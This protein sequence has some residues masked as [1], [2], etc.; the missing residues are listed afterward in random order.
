M[1]SIA[2]VKLIARKAI[3]DAANIVGIIE[4]LESS[5]TGKVNPTINAANAG[6]AALQIQLS[7]IWRLHLIVARTYLSPVK[8]GD[9]HLKAG[10]ELL[11]K[12]AIR[13]G[14]IAPGQG[15]TFK[16]AESE[17]LRGCGD[18]R[19]P[20]IISTRH[21]FI[22]HLG[23]P[24]K[25]AAIPTYKDLFDFARKTASIME[26]FANSVGVAGSADLSQEKESFKKSADQFWKPWSDK[27]GDDASSKN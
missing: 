23:E 17:W 26:L 2:T 6:A 9:L 7:L 25:D 5:N 27:S 14:C 19:L 3:E 11:K 1:K 15:D 4:I 18:H 10:F 16:K 8:S 21:K 20:D 13:Q 22:A 24:D 12:S